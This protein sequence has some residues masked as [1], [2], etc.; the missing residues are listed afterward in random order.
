MKEQKRIIPD[1]EIDKVKIDEMKLFIIQ[2][3]EENKVLRKII[4]KLNSGNKLIK[5]Q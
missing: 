1:Q 3:K 5:E 2:K 4:D